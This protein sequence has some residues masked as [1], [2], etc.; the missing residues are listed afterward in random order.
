MIKMKKRGTIQK[1]ECPALD[2]IAQE[3]GKLLEAVSTLSKFD[4]QLRFVSGE[5]SEYTREMQD[6]SQE[7]VSVTEETSAGMNQVNHSVTTAA[8]TL[9][10]VTETARA[11]AKKNADSKVLLDEA[12]P[13]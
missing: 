13:L 3:T 10:A 6:I 2:N 9:H 1:P 11:L 7:N 8:D 5:L 12:L 4:V